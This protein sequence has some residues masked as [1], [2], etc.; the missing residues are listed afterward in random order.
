MV[1]ELNKKYNYGKL[2]VFLAFAAAFFG[3]LNSTFDFIAVPLSA[4]FT[5]AL[6]AVSFPKRHGAVILALVCAGI[7]VLNYFVGP[8]AFFCAVLSSVCGLVI[9]VTYVYKRSKTESVVAV[10]TVAIA[11]TLVALWIG[12]AR[13][14]G[15]FQLS[16]VKD[17]YAAKL[18]EFKIFFLENAE[19]SLASSVPADQL[20]LALSEAQTYLNAYALLLPSLLV[21]A[22]LVITGCAF[23]IF[24]FLMRRFSEDESYLLAWRFTT[25]NVFVVFYILLAFVN[26]FA[27]ETNVFSVS[28][29][30]LY[31]IFN[32]VYAYI[33]YNFVTAMLAQ[34][35]RRGV[36]AMA[37]II[38]VLLLSSLAIQFL[39]VAGAV[40]SFVSNRSLSGKGP[41]DGSHI[42]NNES[43]NDDEE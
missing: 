35:W 8:L 6:F 12:A 15:T 41:K 9:G 26:A 11:L 1:F 3:L 16:D 21:V 22:A 20:G 43:E 14:I 10:I 2:V 38:G 40:F 17:F 34:R 24:T 39:A 5:A 33:G 18:Y 25:S 19:R 36:A 30:N 31:S 23:K 37:V 7:C 42:N 32:F 28:V 29:A 13:S 27:T 4:A